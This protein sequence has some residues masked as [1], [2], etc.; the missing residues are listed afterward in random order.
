MVMADGEIDVTL[1]DDLLV[2]CSTHIA[3]ART[4]TKIMARVLCELRRTLRNLWF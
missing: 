2:S 3:D 4:Q 1:L